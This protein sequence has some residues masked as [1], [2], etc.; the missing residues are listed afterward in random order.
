MSLL[1]G[2]NIKAWV[3]YNETHNWQEDSNREINPVESPIF[4]IVFIFIRTENHR[5]CIIFIMAVNK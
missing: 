4:D 2:N 5:K 3:K 1:T